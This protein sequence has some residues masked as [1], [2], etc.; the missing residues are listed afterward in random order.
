M[1]ARLNKVD[2]WFIY[3]IGVIRLAKK[4]CA[5]LMLRLAWHSAGTFV[6]WVRYIYTIYLISA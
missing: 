1:K 5:P 2:C 3:V 4:R 6:T